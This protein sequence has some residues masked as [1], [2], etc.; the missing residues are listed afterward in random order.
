MLGDTAS[1][2]A[3]A[4]PLVVGA[5]LVVAFGFH[6]WMTAPSETTRRRAHERHTRSRPEPLLDVHLFTDRS[7]LPASLT[8][9]G[10][11]A[12]LF[13]ALILLPLYYQVDRGES[14][15]VAGLLMAP[16]GIGAAL[17][18]QL[19]GRLSDR[20]G[21]GRVVPAG[22]VVVIIG[23]L[24]YTMVGAN[25]SYA[26]LATALFVRGIGFGFTMMPATAAAYQN[27]KSAQVPRAT[28][29]INILQRVGGS[30][31]TALLAVI[32]EHQIASQF[33]PAGAA[34]SSGTTPTAAERH[35]FAGPVATAFGHTFWWVVGMTVVALIPSLFLSRKPAA[36]PPLAP[37][38]Q[39]PTDQ[40][41]AEVDDDDSIQP[42]PVVVSG[43]GPDG[44][45]RHRTQRRTANRPVT[46]PLE[47]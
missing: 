18:M 33:A 47:G 32:L 43:D 16:Q 10:F 34:I 38:A 23:T 5:A 42:A 28:T 14:A 7:F 45:R 1:A 12:A 17:V 24:A 35:V 41:R 30:I 4:I 9:F 31:G 26:F 15:L 8:S 3:I 46:P 20:L 44:P 19:A 2:A 6:A 39:P 21:P 11:G 27:L 36:V 25:T 40:P 22:F 13:G 29:S 37:P